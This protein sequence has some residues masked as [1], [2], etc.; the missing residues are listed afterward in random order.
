MPTHALELAALALG[1]AVIAFLYASVGH[2]G[3]SGY[4]AV[5]SLFGL[6]PDVI[7]PTALVLNVAVASI[8]TFQF[9]R[10][11][12]FSWRLFWPFALFAVPLAFVG[13]SLAL[14]IPIFK[15]LV[16][17]VLLL[18]AVRFLLRPGDDVVRSTPS[19]PVAL[20]IGGGLGLLAGLTGT[21]GGIFLTPI[22]LFFRWARARAAAAV[23]AL[24]ILVNSLAGLAGNLRTTG[25][26]PDVAAPLMV[27]VVV[28]GAAGSHLGS[29]RLSP[30]FIKRLLA[31]VLL[32]AGSK[33]VLGR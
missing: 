27:A 14:P 17:T 26:I 18:S 11:G 24:F 6:A 25:A 3:A 22:L 5:M 15:T 10:A 20:S 21:G 29:R 9:W 8:G 16:G 33:L 23:S 12:H 4:I 19:R 28:G 13:G 30:V 1:V 31:V 32:I 2:A 7:R